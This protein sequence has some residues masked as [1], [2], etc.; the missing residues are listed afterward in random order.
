MD[1]PSLLQEASRAGYS[2]FVLPR[3]SIRDR[4]SFFEAVRDTLPLD[5][6][7]VGSRSWDALSDSLWEGLRTYPSERIVILWPDADRMAE[8]DPDDFEIAVNLLADITSTLGSPTL[9]SGDPK[10]IVV[11]IERAST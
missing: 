9:T 4:R 1:L 3:K 7:V 10:E 6:P 2:T 8:S 11:L 5:P